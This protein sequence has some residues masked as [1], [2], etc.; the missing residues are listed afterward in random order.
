METARSELC[1]PILCATATVNL[2][3]RSREKEALGLTGIVLTSLTAGQ[4][5][6]SGA[7]SVYGLN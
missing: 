2:V 1:L 3:Y 5:F 6:Y 7:V 4:P